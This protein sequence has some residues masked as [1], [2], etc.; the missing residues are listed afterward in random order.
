MKRTACHHNRHILAAPWLGGW[1]SVC[2]CLVLLAACGWLFF[3]DIAIAA[4]PS[5][6]APHSRLL[7]LQD[8]LP[9]STVMA[10]SVTA[11]PDVL[12]LLIW[13]GH[14]P[15]A[16]IERFEKQVENRHGRSVKLTITYVK[17]GEEFYDAIRD[18]AVDVVMM[19]HHA[20]KDERFNYIKNRLLLPIDLANIPNFKHVIS[21]IQRAEYLLSGEQVYAVPVSQGPYGLAYNTALLEKEPQSW[22][23]FW[24]PQFKRQYVLAGNEYIYNVNITALALGYSR[25]TDRQL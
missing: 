25:E 17:G 12:R 16:W 13:E 19:T 1:I 15:D 4:E 5:D 14:A 20:Y 7:T 23:I 21:A 2:S 24:D 9:A 3:H 22:N 11:E 18:R 6:D 10:E 8:G